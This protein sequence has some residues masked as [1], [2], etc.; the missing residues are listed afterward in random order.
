MYSTQVFYYIQRQIVVLLSGDSPRSFMP[1]YAKPITIHKGV[2]NQVQFQL[3]NQ[4][5]K[6]VDITGKQIICRLISY[7]GNRVL[8]KKALTLQL[9]VTGIAALIITAA[10][11]ENIDTQKC[12]YSLEIPVG[13]FNYPVYVDPMSGARGDVN[14]VNS[15]LPSFVPSENVTIPTDQ[16]FP[17]TDPSLC[18]TLGGVQLTYYS[19]VIST[20]DNPVL[21][22]Q[23]SYTEYTGNVIVE[24]STLPDGSWYTIGNVNQYTNYTD[25]EGYVVNGYHPYIRMKFSSTYGTV[26]DILA[27]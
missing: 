22:L 14:I 11:I 9:P 16:I 19:S 24:G 17:N 13:T 3:L 10:E 6:T 2:D 25:T 23:A 18:N 4:A 15:V 12:Y 26:D 7:D 27:R 8:L 21:T 5:Q 1:F 20:D